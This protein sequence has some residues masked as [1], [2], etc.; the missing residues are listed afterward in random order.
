[1][2]WIVS[3]Q[4]ETIQHLGNYITGKYPS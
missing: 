2:K 1:V 3:E 4:A